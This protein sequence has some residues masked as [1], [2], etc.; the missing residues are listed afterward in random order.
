MIKE[1]IDIETLT[2]Y[3]PAF[4]LF[5]VFFTYKTFREIKMQNDLQ[6]GA[7]L[8]SFIDLYNTHEASDLKIESMNLY[9]R[10]KN[11]LNGNQYLIEQNPCYVSLILANRGRSDIVHWKLQIEL[12]VD[13]GDIL[14]DEAQT[15][16]KWEITSDVN[17]IISFEHERKVPILIK[18]AFPKFEINWK[19]SYSD[20]RKAKYPSIT[21]KYINHL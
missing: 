6:F 1:F 7:I 8:L 3:R 20:F 18:N 13:G 5:Y 15:S 2:F 11:L 10:W 16:T 21:G 12:L 9:N 4:W 17:E 14:P 19:I